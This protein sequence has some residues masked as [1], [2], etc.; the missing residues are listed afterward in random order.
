MKVSIQN[1]LNLFVVFGLVGFLGCAK[2]V[3]VVDTTP[4]EK[5]IHTFL[6]EKSMGLKVSAFK[7]LKVDGNSA[8]ATVLLEH[9][10]GMV[11]PKVRWQF[12]FAKDK[13]VWQVTRYKQ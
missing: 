6:R 8:E 3:P 11:G 9:A 5:A 7:E 13:G 4:F 10:E 1:V 2:K 12:W